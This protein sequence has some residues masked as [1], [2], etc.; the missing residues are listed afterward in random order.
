MRRDMNAAFE[1]FVVF[2]EGRGGGYF[3]WERIAIRLRNK[4]SQRPEKD[5]KAGLRLAVHRDLSKMTS[6]HCWAGLFNPSNQHGFEL[7][8]TSL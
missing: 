3:Y 4:G 1:E 8:Y 6:G 5:C 2:G 7:R